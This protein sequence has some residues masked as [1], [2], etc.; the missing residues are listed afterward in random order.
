MRNKNLILNYVFLCCLIILFLND[1]IFKFQYTSWFT[2]K[3]SDIVGIILFPMLLAYLLPKLKEN[4]IFAA[5]LFFTFWK[6]P[7]SESFIKIYNVISPIPIHRIVD[8]SDLLV[9]SLLPIP[10]FLI[11]NINILEQF[12]LKKTNAFAVL[13]P[14][15]LVLMSTSQMR[16]YTYSPETGVLTFRDI[17][18]EIRKTKEDLL[19]EIQSQNIVLVKDTAFIL[20]SARYEVSRM[21]KLDQTALEKGGDIF[22]IDNADLKDVLLKEIERSS[23]YKIQ[24]IKIGDRTIK[25]LRF[26]IKPALMKMS[27]KKFSQIVVHG[28]EIDKNLDN[29]KVGERLKEIYQSIITSKFKH[30]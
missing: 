21:G 4:S 8:Y 29:D 25:N 28:A 23:D 10:Y 7:F 14:T 2:G 27:P 19:K 30:F 18:F 11:K 5:G 20:E 3:L 12:S 1:H 9:L 17:Q 24:E 15:I 16:T 13:L 6:S 26:S 22:K